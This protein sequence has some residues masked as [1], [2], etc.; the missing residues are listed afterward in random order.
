MWAGQRQT[1]LNF[2]LQNAS[3]SN[4]QEMQQKNAKGKEMLQKALQAWL[5]YMYTTS[6]S[7]KTTENHSSEVRGRGDGAK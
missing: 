3:K 7:C 2:S 6:T 4:V 5:K 1:H